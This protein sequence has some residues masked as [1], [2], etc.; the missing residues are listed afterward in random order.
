MIGANNLKKS[1]K[2]L[3]Y[4]GIFPIRNHYYEPQFKFNKDT[5]TKISKYRKITGINLNISEQ[6]KLLKK[7]KFHNEL[8]NLELEKNNKKKI[9]L[10]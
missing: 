1:T 7:F 3:K 2:L 5:L 6:L 9:C 10:I 8:L 4:L